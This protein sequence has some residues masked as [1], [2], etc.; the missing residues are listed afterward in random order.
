MALEKFW[1]PPFW[2]PP[3]RNKIWQKW[4]ICITHYILQLT[5]LKGLKSITGHGGQICR[6]GQ[7]FFSSAPNY[8]W[9]LHSRDNRYLNMSPE[10]STSLANCGWWCCWT[11]GSPGLLRDLLSSC[12]RPQLWCLQSGN[13]HFTGDELKILKTETL[14]TQLL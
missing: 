2:W 6:S 3:S 9:S 5:P 11:T 1:V 8:L 14:P 7:G 10:T 12:P 4:G 13:K